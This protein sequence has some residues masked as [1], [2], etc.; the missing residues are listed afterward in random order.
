[1]RILRLVVTSLL[2]ASLL[3]A[4]AADSY[5]PDWDP[6]GP[7]G[8]GKADGL[9]DVLQVLTFGEVVE[10]DVGGNRSE[11]YVI[12][13]KRTDRIELAMTVTSGNLDPH[14]SLFYGTSTYIGSES[15]S[16]SGATLKKVYRVEDAGRYLIAV[17]A[18]QGQGS[19]DYKLT[20]TCAGG[21]CAGELPPPEVLSLPV[22]DVAECISKIRR[23][24]F[25]ALP[26]FNGAVGA[27]RAKQIMDECSATS[28]LSDGSSCAG[29]CDWVG[30]DT[31]NE[32]DD[33]AP[34]CNSLEQALQFY[35]D[36]PATC[37]AALDS[38]FGD[39]YGSGWGNSGDELYDTDEVICWSSTL[40]GNC[41]SFARSTAACG[42][43]ITAGSARECTELCESTTGAHV[44]D[45][46]TIC[47][48]DSDCDSY[49]DIDLG[50]AGAACGGLTSANRTCLENWLDTNEAYIC[51]NSLD[52]VIGHP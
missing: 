31:N 13:L 47:S 35:A 44:D 1:M 49:C 19:G 34:V 15:W 14:L 22:D 8:G 33:A 25:A 27:A 2:S 23:C 45:L 20:V 42:G 29:V 36:Q 4:C 41:D 3:A 51:T 26:A 46:D 10:G 16:R 9:L 5:D 30:E 48:S 24:A 43:T 28:S 11:L 6:N 12:D 39:C 21:P 50:E 32:W 18:Y 17:R 37:T 40:N 38:C 52:D 7:V